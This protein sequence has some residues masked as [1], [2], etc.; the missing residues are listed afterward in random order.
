MKQG[1]LIRFAMPL[2][3]N[4]HDRS[5]TRLTHIG[6]L[7]EHDK[8]LQRATVLYQGFLHSIHQAYCQKAGKKDG[9]E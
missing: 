7:I 4:H 2:E 1:D 6:I 3:I 8:V 5:L 9:L